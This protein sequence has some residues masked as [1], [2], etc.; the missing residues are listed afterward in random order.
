MACGVN[1]W[2]LSVRLCRRTWPARR[3]ARSEAWGCAAATPCGCHGPTRCR[4]TDRCPAS[5]SLLIPLT[6]SCDGNR[7][8][9]MRVQHQQQLVSRGLAGRS[10]TR[11]PLRRLCPCNQ[12]GL[13][14]ARTAMP[15]LTPRQHPHSPQLLLQEQ[16]SHRCGKHQRTERKPVLPWLQ[17]SLRMRAAHSWVVQTR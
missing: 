2:K 16:G 5:T 8:P 15:H 6:E 1:L 13:P 9:L 12:P 10:V 14:A 17:C 3:P 7:P 11:G 4:Y